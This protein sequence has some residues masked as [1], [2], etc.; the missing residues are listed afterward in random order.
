MIILVGGSGFIGSNLAF[1]L[2]KKKI[3]FRILDIK[4]NPKLIA[5]TTIVNILDKK[6]L[7]NC[8]P[9]NSVI[10]NLAAVHYDDEKTEDYYLVNVQGSKNLCAAA[11][12]KNCRRIIFFSSVSVY[13]FAKPF[14]DENSPQNANNHYGKSKK[15]AELAYLNWNIKNKNN[16]L[17]ILRPT[18]IFGPGNRGNIFNL[19][20]Q[21][22]KG[23]IFIVGN[24]KNT[25]SL[26]YIENITDFILYIL[27]LKDKI[28]I[29]NYVDEPQLTLK[30]LII[31]CKIKFNNTE[32]IKKIPYFILFGSAFILDFL[33][34]IF[35]KKFKI[36]R[37]RIKKLVTE[38]SYKA[39]LN[40]FV[41]K[42]TL[43]QG[44]EK[45]IKKEFDIF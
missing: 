12:L 30:E 15:K 35:N 39:N 13:G 38:S 44:L 31:F 18:A 26:A 27:P 6:K 1:K 9:A 33:S 37:M 25:K 28:M 24:G 22:Y 34:F 11:L 5:H 23:P 45:T 21:I 10:I 36:N 40:G 41:P 19:I 20:N 29:H 17:V 3:N 2:I 8:I 32:N 43:K 14:A 7:I 42:Y 16:K 4:I